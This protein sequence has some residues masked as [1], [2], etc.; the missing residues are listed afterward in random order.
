MLQMAKKSILDIEIF[1]MYGG[2]SLWGSS[3]PPWLH[4]H[5]LSWQNHVTAKIARVTAEIS[6]VVAVIAQS[7]QASVET[8]ICLPKSI[9]LAIKISL[10]FFYSNWF[11]AMQKWRKH[12]I[13]QHFHVLL[14]VGSWIFPL[15]KFNQSSFCEIEI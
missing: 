9:Y 11:V 6:W 10:L 12:V 4:R 15:K 3:R 14:S 1:F 2:S 5:I 7:Y 13:Q 8:K